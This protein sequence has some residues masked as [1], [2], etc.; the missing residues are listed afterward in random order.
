V[1]KSFEKFPFALFRDLR[2]QGTSCVIR[3]NL[4]LSQSQAHTYNLSHSTCFSE[5]NCV[6]IYVSHNNRINV[7][8]SVEFSHLWMLG[9]FICNSNSRIIKQ[10][11]A[12]SC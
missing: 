3:S 11:E 6:V 10:L 9:E 12:F 4:L 1:E 8:I 7:F 2:L 5:S